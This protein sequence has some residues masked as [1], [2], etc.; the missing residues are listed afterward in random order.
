MPSARVPQPGFRK[1][2]PR[3]QKDTPSRR[4]RAAQRL[5]VRIETATAER[6]DAWADSNAPL[7]AYAEKQ[8]GQAYGDKRV[9][10]REL[11]KAGYPE[12]RPFDRHMPGGAP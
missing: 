8:L 5:T 11:F 10:R 7:S 9:E 1:V 3:K 12:G 4:L 6:R 2:K